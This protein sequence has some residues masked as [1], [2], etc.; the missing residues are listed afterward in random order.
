[1]GVMA[2]PFVGLRSPADTS[3]GI[4]VQVGADGITIQGNF[5]GMDAPDGSVANANV[6][7]IV[8][9]ARATVGGANAAHRNLISRNVSS[10]IYLVDGDGTLIQGNLIGTDPS[11]TVIR[12]N[13]AGGI[14]VEVDVTNLT[15]GTGTLG[16]VISGNDLSGILIDTADTVTIRGNRIGTNGAGTAALPND[17][18]GIGMNDTVHVTIGGTGAGEGNLISGNAGFGMSATSDVDLRVQGNIVGLNLAGHGRH[19]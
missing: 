14:Y 5:V 8:L 7:G 12:Q 11:A 15:I 9:L 2:P 17:G 1:M 13:G 18:S 19:S 4:W 16:N 3:E 6:V 10:G